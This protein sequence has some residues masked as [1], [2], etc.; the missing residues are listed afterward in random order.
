MTDLCP[1]GYVLRPHVV[2]FGEEVPLLEKAAYIVSEADVLVVIGTS[3]N[4]YPAANLVDYAPKNCS[5]FI[6]DPK[7]GE[8][9]VPFGFTKI[10][11]TAVEGVVLL[12]D[13]LD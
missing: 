13:Y 12:N 6:I 4:V 7:V 11:A 1:D 9:P 10:P 8:L 2:W 3:L 5:C